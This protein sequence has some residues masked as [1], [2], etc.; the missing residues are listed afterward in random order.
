MKGHEEQCKDCRYAGEFR[1]GGLVDCNY[2]RMGITKMWE[3]DYCAA[4]WGK[5]P[6]FDKEKEKK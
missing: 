5:D 6:E 2:N 3:H 4:Q 1:T